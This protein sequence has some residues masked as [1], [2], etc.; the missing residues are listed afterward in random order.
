MI[1]IIIISKITSLVEMSANAFNAAKLARFEDAPHPP[2]YSS[3]T[4]PL[5]HF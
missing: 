5:A 4:S 1:L 3:Y 2:P